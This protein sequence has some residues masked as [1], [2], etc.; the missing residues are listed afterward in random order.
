MLLNA[1]KQR[2][3]IRSP[4]SDTVYITT[5]AVRVENLKVERFRSHTLVRAPCRNLCSTFPPDKGPSNG[6]SNMHRKL[7]KFGNLMFEICLRTDRETY[8]DTFIA[9]LRTCRYRGA[10]QSSVACWRCADSVNVTD[11]HGDAVNFTPISDRRPTVD[12]PITLDDQHSVTSLTSLRHCNH[13]DDVTGNCRLANCADRTSR[14]RGIE[15]CFDRLSDVEILRLRILHT[16]LNKYSRNH[17]FNNLYSSTTQQTDIQNT[18]NKQPTTNT[19][20]RPKA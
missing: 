15:S 11:H 2:Y 16:F 19:K 13:G 14:D 1:R 4:P 5:L 18:T 20:L 6:H 17:V 8:P 9:V 3:F 7:M 12:T 10:K